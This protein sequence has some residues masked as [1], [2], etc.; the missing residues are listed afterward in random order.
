MRTLYVDTCACVIEYE[1]PLVYADMK[2]II[3][4]RTHTIPAQVIA[5]NRSFNFRDGREPTERQQDQ[6]DLDKD[7]ERKK[8]EFQRR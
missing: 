2:L 5:H 8:P 3:R 7:T 6:I 1:E 4:C